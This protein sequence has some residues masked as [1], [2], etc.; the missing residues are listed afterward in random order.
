M[1]DFDDYEDLNDYA[2]TYPVKDMLGRSPNLS[3]SF[4]EYVH[5][6]FILWKINFNITSVEYPSIIK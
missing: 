6:I 3:F 5:R 1:F 4:G 2:Y